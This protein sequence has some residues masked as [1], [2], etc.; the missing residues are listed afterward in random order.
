ML[1]MKCLKNGIFKE[2]KKRQDIWHTSFFGVF[3]KWTAPLPEQLILK[4]Q[5]GCKVNVLNL[6]L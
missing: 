1:S 4:L 3:M 2:I 6:A 5:I